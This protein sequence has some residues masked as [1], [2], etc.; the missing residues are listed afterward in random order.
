MTLRVHINAFDLWEDPP[1]SAAGQCPVHGSSLKEAVHDEQFD[2]GE[3]YQDPASG[4]R[5]ELS[6]EGS[7]SPASSQNMHAAFLCQSKCMALPKPSTACCFLAKAPGCAPL[8]PL[9]PESSDPTL[10]LS[11]NSMYVGRRGEAQ[12]QSCISASSAS[13]LP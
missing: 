1:P 10:I 11:R 4:C 6:P 3:Q 12:P 13:L 8:S 7:V 5:G 9:A 2:R